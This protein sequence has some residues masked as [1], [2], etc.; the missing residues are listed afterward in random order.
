MRGQPHSEE[1]KAAVLAALTAGDSLAECSRRFGLNLSTIRNWKRQAG[2]KHFPADPTFLTVNPVNPQKKQA[3]KNE[4][5]P[6][7]PPLPR[8]NPHGLIAQSEQF[9]DRA[10][11][12]EQTAADLA[13]LHG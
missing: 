2:L 8:Q 10:W 11:L 5:G 7:G 1:T 3:L 6:L 13:L 9:A 4:I 12:R